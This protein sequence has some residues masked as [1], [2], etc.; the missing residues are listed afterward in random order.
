MKEV[1][2]IQN[3]AYN[4]HFKVVHFKRENLKTTHY[5]IQSVRYLG[6][7]IWDMISNNIKNFTSSN[8]FKNSDKS[9]KPNECPC[10][11]CKEYFA[12]VGFI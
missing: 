8:K 1:F 7:K 2:K 9:W 4:F 10:R 3:S 11:L 12:Q 5:G 6:P